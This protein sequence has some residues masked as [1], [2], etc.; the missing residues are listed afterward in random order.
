MKAELDREGE[1]IDREKATAAAWGAQ[2]ERLGR[3]LER[4]Q[5]YL[6]HTSQ[7]AVDQ[8]NRKVDA[9]NMLLEQVRAQE[10]L[11]NRMVELYNAKLEQYG[12]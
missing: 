1:A 3:E 12:R 8:F 7:Y 6:N 9:Y 5:A 10:R 4:D 2:L 11:V